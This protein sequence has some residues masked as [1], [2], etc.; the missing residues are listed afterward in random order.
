MQFLADQP[1]A[2]RPAVQ[3]GNFPPWSPRRFGGMNPLWNN[4]G[5]RPP[6]IES[7]QQLETNR[8]ATRL[9]FIRKRIKSIEF[10][11]VDDR[12]KTYFEIGQFRQFKSR[13]VDLL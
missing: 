7:N 5:D 11:D 9:K 3:H 12:L 8:V 1:E 10:R 2:A 6:W 13:A 4:R